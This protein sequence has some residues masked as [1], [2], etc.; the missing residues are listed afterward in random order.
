M[1]SSMSHIYFIQFQVWASHAVDISVNKCLPSALFWGCPNERDSCMYWRY[2]SIMSHPVTE[3]TVEHYP[4]S[5]SITAGTTIVLWSSEEKNSTSG[6]PAGHSELFWTVCWFQQAIKLS[7][8]CCTRWLKQYLAICM[9][10]VCPT[11]RRCS[12]T[13]SWKK[14]IQGM[15]V[16]LSLLQSA[17]ILWFA[18]DF[19]YICA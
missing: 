16:D 19:P 17:S 15:I 1:I 18:G 10:T 5:S 9:C 3:V 14:S 2:S 8:L 11:R 6:L 7:R 12:S 13:I 4:S